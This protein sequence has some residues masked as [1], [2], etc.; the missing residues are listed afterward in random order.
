MQVCVLYMLNLFV[1]WFRCSV[2]SLMSA[3]NRFLVYMREYSCSPSFLCQNSNPI[4]LFCSLIWN[5]INIAKLNFVSCAVRVCNLW[6]HVWRCQ[7][8]RADRKWDR[9]R[10]REFLI[11]VHLNRKTWRNHTI[12]QLYVTRHF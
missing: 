7:I 6:L 12:R 4:C 10:G 3:F 2:L 8:A 11:F 1:A 5:K 9:K